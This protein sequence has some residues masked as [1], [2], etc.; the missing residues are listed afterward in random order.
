MNHATVQI[1]PYISARGVVVAEDATSGLVTIRD[2]N[3]TLTGRPIAP[4]IVRLVSA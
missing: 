4:A 2:G 1:S 3:R